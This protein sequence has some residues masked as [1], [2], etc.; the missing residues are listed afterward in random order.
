[1]AAAVTYEFYSEVYG[2]GLSEAAFG[3][4][5]PAASAHVRWLCGGRRP[6]RGEVERI[7]AR[8]GIELAHDGMVVEL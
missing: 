1:V 8:R 6:C 2:G 3:L 5:L 4:A 7:A